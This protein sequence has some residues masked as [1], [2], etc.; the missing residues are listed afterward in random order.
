[1]KKRLA[2]VCAV[3]MLL[4]ALPLSGCAK[5]KSS[6]SKDSSSANTTTEAAT[7]EATTEAPDPSLKINGE[8]L[9]IS[10]LVMCTI[11]GNDISF[12]EY[13]YN[14]YYI[15]NAYA[16][17]LGVTEDKMKSYDDD[18]KKE[19]FD[20]LKDKV[21]SFMQSTY[22]YMKYADDNGI[23]LT[24]EE[25]QNCADNIAELKS[26]KGDEFPKY[27]NNSYLTEDYLLKLLE[28]TALAAKVSKSFEISDEE[29]LKIAENE[30]CQVKSILIPFGY[31]MTPSDG[32]LEKVGVD[33]FDSLSNPQKMNLLPVTFSALDEDGQAKQK[34]K[35]EKYVKDI[36]KKANNGD[37]FDEL[38]TTYGFDGGM[39]QYTGGYVIGNFYTDYDLDY[40]KAACDLKVGEISDI[41]ETAYGY[42]IIKRVETDLDYIKQNIRTD[43]DSSSSSDANFKEEYQTMCEYKTMNEL[44]LDITV[45]ESDYLKNLQYGDLK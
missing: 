17:S 4:T 45:S 21:I 8:D 37:D 18:E 12:A 20:A 29:F 9:D 26:E 22:A 31:D 34:K 24:D 3:L 44:L 30:L 32:L 6:S 43:D 15:L 41:V 25:K 13:R 33:N 11:Y 19:H 28:Q 14:Y 39:L 35:A 23:T 2:A 7:E 16:S 36:L 42:Q 27:L 38:I 5:D 10:N 40:V 1:M